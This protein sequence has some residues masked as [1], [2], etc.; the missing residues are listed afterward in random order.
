MT[1]FIMI[2]AFYT[3]FGQWTIV[4]KYSFVCEESE[5]ESGKGREQLNPKKN[6]T[7]IILNGFL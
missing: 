7:H 1:F 6:N 2:I 4:K 5:N 3:K